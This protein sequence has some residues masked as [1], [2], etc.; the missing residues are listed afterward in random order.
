MAKEKSI[1]EEAIIQMKNL[2]EAVAENAK[3]ILASTMKEEINQLVKESLS[4]QDDEMEVDAEVD[5]DMDDEELDMD[6]DADNEEDMDMEIDMDMDSDE[7]PIDLTDAS[8]EEILKVFKAMGEEDGIIVKK[9]GEDIHLSDT[10]ADTEY[11]VKLGE[12]EEDKNLEEMQMDEMDDVDT[13]S[14]I[15]AIFS[16][17]G[18]IE[19]DQEME[20][21][22]EVM[23]EIEFEDD[24][25]DEDMMDESDDMLDEEDDEDQM[26]ESDDM[27]DEED[28]EDMM[29]ESDDMLDEEDDEDMMDEDDDMLDEAYNHKKAKK[30]SNGTKK[31]VIFPPLHQH[32]RTLPFYYSAGG[33]LKQEGLKSDQK[34]IMTSVSLFSKK[35]WG[36]EPAGVIYL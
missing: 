20:D 27:L 32:L 11:L 13:Q 36:R 25:D 22:E 4:E 28:D 6:V 35:N 21:D 5:M 2:E 10:N 16:N 19:D 29:D 33:E 9:D 8:D 17:D 26:D 24:D 14:V 23:Y 30:S 31:T 7:T 18:N 34:F 12:S 3:G 1:V 15:D